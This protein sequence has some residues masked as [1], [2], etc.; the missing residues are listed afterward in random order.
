MGYRKRNRS[1]I[2]KVDLGDAD[3][4]EVIKM[5]T[6][7]QQSGKEEMPLVIDDKTI[8]MVSP[9]KCNEMYRRKYINTK[10]IKYKIK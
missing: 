4:E 9:E 7:Y 2:S 3:R 8:I 1:R 6:N 5:I 10:M